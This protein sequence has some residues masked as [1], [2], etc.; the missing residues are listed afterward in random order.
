[1]K[2]SIKGETEGVKKRER[3]EDERSYLTALTGSVPANNASAPTAKMAMNNTKPAGMAGSNQ[4][5]ATRT[6]EPQVHSY[7]RTTKPEFAIVVCCCR[8]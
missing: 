7:L 2:G 4:K 6:T 8:V 3:H 1:M 5:A